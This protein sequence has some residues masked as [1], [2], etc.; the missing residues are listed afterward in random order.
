MKNWLHTLRDLTRVHREDRARRYDEGARR[1]RARARLAGATEV[2]VQMEAGW[3]ASRAQGQ[4]H[5]IENVEACGSERLRITCQACGSSHDRPGRCGNSLLCVSCRGALASEKRRKF[6]LARAAVLATAQNRGLVNA[7]RR[8]GRYSEKFLTLTTPHFAGDSV[9]SRIVRTAKAWVFFRRWLKA[10]TR[11]RSAPTLEW[12]RVL[13]W[14]PGESDDAGH[15]H[16][17]LWIFS[18]YLDFEVLKA[19]WRLA[20]IK[21]GG[22]AELCRVVIVH[23]E[24]FDPRGDRGAQELIKYLTKDIDANGDKLAPEIYAEVYKA[25]DGRRITQASQGF[26]ALAESAA[27]RCECGACLPRRVRRLPAD[28]PSGMDA[29]AA[30]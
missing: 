13:E 16:L 26:M 27:S 7:R 23:I 12:F 10:Y 29:E 8:G 25:F 4:R 24:E 2:S 15:P 19:A 20:L 18:C 1:K 9:A 3:H 21:A 22:P 11:S 30:P 28:A 5:K 17:H 6:L 14:T